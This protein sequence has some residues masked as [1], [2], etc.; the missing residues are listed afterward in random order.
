MLLLCF[1]ALARRSRRVCADHVRFHSCLHRAST[2]ALV[3]GKIY[4]SSMANNVGVYNQALSQYAII[5]LYLLNEDHLNSGQIFLHF[6]VHCL[7]PSM[8]Q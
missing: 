1:E 2:D 3:K 6:E 4:F 5:M 8:N 7:Y